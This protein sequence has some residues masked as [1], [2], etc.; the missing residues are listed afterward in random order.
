MRTE[1]QILL[2]KLYENIG[3]ETSSVQDE[4]SNAIDRINENLTIEE[5]ARVVSDI[6]KDE[7]GSH[8]IEVFKNLIEDYFKQ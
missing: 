7:Y 8:N 2:E 5:F 4:I 3:N 6:V 1:D